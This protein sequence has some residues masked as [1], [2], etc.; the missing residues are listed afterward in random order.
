MYGEGMAQGVTSMRTRSLMVAAVL[1]ALPAVARADLTVVSTAPRS[2]AQRVDPNLSQIRIRFSA[3]VRTDRYSVCRTEEGRY[4]T[5]T[6]P[7]TFEEGGLVCLLP[8]KLRPGTVYSLSINSEDYRGFCSAA[9]RNVTAVPYLLTFTTSGEG[10]ATKGR[11]QRWREDLAYLANTLP[12]KHMNLF[13]HLPEEQFRAQVADLDR[14][15]PGLDEDHIAIELAKL[16]ASVGDSHTQLGAWPA[17]T[18]RVLPL[19]LHW[20]R[21]GTY[22]VAAGAP[23]QRLLGCRLVRIGSMEVAA[24]CARVAATIPHENEAWVKSQ[25]PSQLIFPR[26]LAALSIIPDPKGAR[27]WFLTPQGKEISAWIVGVRPKEITQAAVAIDPSSDALPV[28][29]RKLGAPYWCDYVE[30]P[31]VIYAQYNQCAN[32]PGYPVSAFQEDVEKLLKEHAAAPLVMDLRNNSGGNSA[33]LDP[34]IEKLAAMPRFQSPGSLFVIVGRRT[35]SSGLLNAID[36]RDKAKAIVVGEPTGGKPNCY[37]EVQSFEL[38][39]SGLPVSY[40]TKFF[41]TTDHGTPSLMPDLPAELSYAD[42][43]AGVDPAM[44]AIE[45]QVKRVK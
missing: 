16:V 37:G 17:L 9:D 19:Q 43:A 5:V 45:Q 40:S 41:R 1:L 22:V 4:P 18:A 31:G 26:L 32:A 3:P 35:F 10:P 28:Y 14:R 42:F 6:G 20:F 24:A 39:N 44:E 7:L 27:L 13:F 30:P 21:D 2:G 8:V 34:L 11:T 23:H 38:P 12:A 29:L 33:L 15:L 25:V 36:L